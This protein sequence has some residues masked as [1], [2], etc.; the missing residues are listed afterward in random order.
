MPD[1]LINE[2]L[3]WQERGLHYGDGLFETILK[4]GGKIS[5]WEAHYQRLTKGCKQLHLPVPDQSWLENRL[6]EASKDENNCVVKIVVTRGMGGRGLTLPAPDQSSVFVLTYP[7]SPPGNTPL[8]LSVS[9]TRLPINPNLAGLKHLNRLDYVLATIELSK[10]KNKD[11]AILCD[12]DGY[13]IEGI[14]SNLFFCKGGDIYTP[15]LTLAGVEGI[16]RSKVIEQFEKEGRQINVNR[17]KLD[18]LFEADE[19][20]LCNSVQGIRPIGSIDS[21]QFKTG[22]ITKMMTQYFNPPVQTRV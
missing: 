7:Y 12:T 13:I 2:T 15:S 4:N 17:F 14:I 1:Q 10:K 11:E 22:T 18:Q 6:E 9:Q 19:C 5:Y 16:M 20:F 3:G 8:K 21:H